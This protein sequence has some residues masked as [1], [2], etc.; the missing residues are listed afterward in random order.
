MKPRPGALVLLFGLTADQEKLVRITGLK[1]GLRCRA[2]PAAQYETPLEQLVANQPSETAYEGDV[3]AAQALL[4]SG[5]PGSIL[6]PFLQQLRRAGLPTSV[7]KAVLTPD[8]RHWTPLALLDE[9]TK[10]RDAIAAG[11]S[12]A[13][14]GQA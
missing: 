10:E 2:I 6:T 7:L 4:L 1:W 5:I 13:H 9:L 12:P 11:Q 3:P 14:G 8:N